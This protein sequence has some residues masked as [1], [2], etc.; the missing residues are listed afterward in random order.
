M[1]FTL[2]VNP[3]SSSKKFAL[4]KD[5]SLLINAYVEGGA[6]GYCI[7]TFVKGVQHERKNLNRHLFLESLVDFI[8]TAE[9]LGIITQREEITKA[10]VRVV[11]VGT[12]FQEH[13]EISDEYLKKLQAHESVAPLH[14]PHLLQEIKVIKK[15]LPWAKLIG[16]SD[17][18][19][20]RTMPKLS[21][22]Y[23]LT[24]EEAEKYDLFRFGFHGLSVSSVVRRTHAV[25]GKDPLRAIVCHIG[26]GVS[27]TA[28]KDEQS[29]DT[30]MGYSPGS[31]LIMGSR[32][33]DLDVGAMLYLMQCK[34]LKPIDAITYMQTQGGL[35]GLTGE[36][37]LRFLLEKR[38]Q[39]D[40]RAAFAVDSFVYQ[41][42]KKIGSYMAA[43]GGIDLLIFTATAGERSPVL[44]GLV[45]AGLSEL[46]VEIDDE[47]N[48][49]CVSRDGIISK[50]E[51]KIKI[52]VI[53]TDEA[54][55]INFVSKVI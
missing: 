53:K 3:G 44:R 19:F 18:A 24:D 29:F 55:E 46:G 13:K 37:D 51:S 47:K 40:T 4:Y 21:R 36:K 1:A 33:G 17:S 14:I 39:G 43:L 49:L 23:S 50:M 5:D 22:S 38:A 41:I 26:S 27:V 35:Y 20:H 2:I 48:E 31:G 10:A 54:S 8:K 32:A 52:A 16:A 25:T 9:S 42:R 34:N 11:A 12:Y 28:V 30:S 45:V 7:S 6:D 15:E